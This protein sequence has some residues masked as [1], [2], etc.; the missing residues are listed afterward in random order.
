MPVMLFNDNCTFLATLF[1]LIKSAFHPTKID[2]NHTRNIHKRTPSIYPGS[3]I[4]LFLVKLE[5]SKNN[6]L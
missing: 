3:I 2:W 1:S 6:K 4:L 5:T